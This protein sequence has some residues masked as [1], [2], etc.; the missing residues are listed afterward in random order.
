MAGK[1]LTSADRATSSHRRQNRQQRQQ[2]SP[3]L[4]FE[5]LLALLGVDDEVRNECYRELR[6]HLMLFF[7]RHHCPFP[8]DLADEAIDRVARRLGEGVPLRAE[9]LRFYCGG[10]ARHLYRE[11]LRDCMLQ[12]DRVSRL[13]HLFPD[14]IEPANDPHDRVLDCLDHCLS[15]L[16][17]A[18]RR[19]LLAYYEGDDLAEER[20]KICRELS[21]SPNSLRLRTHRLRRKVESAL[22]AR[23]TG[24]REPG[25][26]EEERYGSGRTRDSSSRQTAS[27]S[28]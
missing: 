7:A 16:P 2:G 18:E 28:R 10:V 13:T 23:L 12:A 11:F 22:R 1:R 14:R 25:A 21:V 26:G 9:A 27:P 8:E 5:K 6:R 17:A 15:L 20:Q 4:G 24:G 19:L 3:H